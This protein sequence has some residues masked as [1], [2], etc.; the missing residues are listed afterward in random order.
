MV[1]PLSF[2][3]KKYLG[4]PQGGEYPDLFRVRE[5]AQDRQERLQRQRLYESPKRRQE[6]QVLVPPE[7]TTLVQ[8]KREGLLT[9]EDVK[10]FSE[11]G[12]FIP[13]PTGKDD[14]WYETAT[15]GLKR[16]RG[17]PKVPTQFPPQDIIREIPPEGKLIKTVVHNATGTEL[18]QLLVK[19]DGTV[20]SGGVYAGK[21]TSEMQMR[22]GQFPKRSHDIVHGID[23]DEGF[24]KMLNDDLETVLE[25]WHQK[26]DNLPEAIQ[27]TQKRDMPPYLRAY[28]DAKEAEE[29]ARQLPEIELSA[30]YSSEPNK[31]QE[32][33]RYKEGFTSPNQYIQGYL[34]LT[35][36]PA[37]W[38]DALKKLSAP[39]EE[40]AKIWAATT[41]APF[42]DTYF[43]RDDI[44]PPTDE[45]K[46]A[47]DFA[48]K[49]RDSYLDE[50]ME[51]SPGIWGVKGFL[52]LTF[53]PYWMPWGRLSMVLGG[54]T[55]AA[56]AVKK[57]WQ[58]VTKAEA[59]MALD[60]PVTAKEVTILKHADRLEALITKAL[61][62]GQ[63]VDKLLGTSTIKQ[64]LKL[65]KSG[66]I[67]GGVTTLSEL[68]RKGAA[69]KRITAVVKK[70]N[71]REKI[72]YDEWID[73]RRYYPK[74]FLELK[75]LVQKYQ[76]NISSGRIKPP[77][78]IKA[79]EKLY[80]VP[81]TK[82]FSV[83][84][85][86][87]GNL[88]LYPIAMTFG[89]RPIKS[90]LLPAYSFR[91]ASA[92]HLTSNLKLARTISKGETIYQIDP[93]VL[94]QKNLKFFY[95]RPSAGG[96]EI[97]LE[98]EAGIVIPKGQWTIVGGAKKGSVP[99][100]VT[101]GA[102]YK[103]LKELGN[104][105]IKNKKQADTDYRKLLKEYEEI[106][107]GKGVPKG[108]PKGVQS[109]ENSQI[110]ALAAKE[111][112]ES[113]PDIPGTRV[114]GMSE[115]NPSG[116]FKALSEGLP[117]RPSFWELPIVRNFV[118][119]INTIPIS[120]SPIGQISIIR[121]QMLDSMD[122]MVSHALAPM[123][124]LK[125]P[126]MSRKGGIVTDK[127]VVPTGASPKVGKASSMHVYDI[128]SYPDTYIIADDLKPWFDEMRSVT[129]E[130]AAYLEKELS[131]RGQKMPKIIGEDGWKYFHRVV[132]RIG[133]IK[134]DAYKSSPFKQRTIDI[135]GKGETLEPKI[136]YLDN[137]AEALEWYVKYAYRHIIDLYEKDLM[138]GLT[139][140]V[141]E[142]IPKTLTEQVL[143]KG[144]TLVAA[145]ELKALLKSASK[146]EE[147]PPSILGEAAIHFSGM[148][149]RIRAL[150]DQPL[151]WKAHAP[152]ELKLLKNDIDDIVRK[153]KK[154]NDAIGKT[155]NEA[156]ASVRKE[157]GSDT[158]VY[159]NGVERFF[160]PY[161][162][163][164]PYMGWTFKPRSFKFVYEDKGK[165]LSGKALAEEV[166]KQF[167]YHPPSLF[168]QLIEATGIGG[169][170]LRETKASLDLSFQF[171]QTLVGGLGLDAWNLMTLKP[172]ANWFKGAS[173]GV[174]MAFMPKS[175][176]KWASKPE[177]MAAQREMIL[178]R[179]LIQGSEY[180][181][182]ITH[183]A[184]LL[185]KTVV[186]KP[187]AVMYERAHDAF[188][189]GRVS[190]ATYMWMGQRP[191]ATKG[192]VAGAKLDR[193][194]DEMG[195]W[196]NKATG[197]LSTRGMG[198][199]PLQRALES[200]FFF[201]PRYNRAVLASIM[202]IAKGGYTGAQARESLLGLI[203]AGTSFFTFVPMAIGQTPRLNPM[204]TS[205]G[206][207]GAKFLT[208]KVGD[209][210]VG[211]GGTIYGLARL[212]ANNWSALTN[213]PE[214]LFKV[215]MDNPNIR[216]LRAKLGPPPSLAI[217]YV[218]GEGY[219]GN[220]TR[221]NLTQVLG[222][223]LNWLVP[224]WMSSVIGD[225]WYDMRG[226]EKQLDS[227]LEAAI[228]EFFGMRTI[229]DTVVDEFMELRDKYSRQ[230]F[231]VPYR[232]L[233]DQADKDS[234][235]E[236]HTDLTELEKD[237]S[238]YWQNKEPER[239]RALNE[240]VEKAKEEKNNNLETITITLLNDDEN[241]HGG[242]SAWSRQ[243]SLIKA[244]AS[245]RQEVLW[246]IKQNDTMK[247]FGGE[248][249][250][251]DWKN[252]QSPNDK[253]LDEYQNIRY[254]PSIL[255]TGLPDWEKRDSDL[256]T[257]LASQS[258]DVK[259]YIEENKNDYIKG[260]GPY[261]Q[262][263][264]RLLIFAQEGLEDYYD[265]IDDP[266]QKRKEYRE[267]NPNVDA[268][269]V[270]SRGLKAVSMEATSR[271]L[272]ILREYGVR[273]GILGEE[274]YGDWKP[275]WLLPEPEIPYHQPDKDKEMESGQSQ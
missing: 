22:I 190:T 95:E 201:A 13:F 82:D 244:Y 30:K 115:F 214:D 198:I 234:L 16:R 132:A 167:G 33:N 26:Y 8:P 152:G 49:V 138:I 116:R 206:G 136:V 196:I 66:E 65:F 150:V 109:A 159:F 68:N 37:S 120:R 228:P 200:V 100:I 42:R 41:T 36:Q 87:E 267:R 236:N 102:E 146:G 154:A 155:Y 259:E 233:E 23:W 168:G 251:E 130:I 45:E 250:V 215:S 226:D 89:M 221:D 175:Y 2:Y 199:P 209:S 122:G 62:K 239:N 240:I 188:T 245:G 97:V 157:L 193:R 93:K 273:R 63:S 229:P 272:D 263:V 121:N 125:A 207:D 268:K 40:T 44:R 110:E 72:N 18:Q 124:A 147:L 114:I 217:D 246:E 179:A 275:I 266:P 29:D 231:N 3:V 271:V 74:A 34:A 227:H 170:I 248:S 104:E 208:I 145:K 35:G 79:Q 70:I 189:A 269:L 261:T 164:K 58:A 265:I 247:F 71:S 202:D 126:K 232:D 123:K 144:K 262:K 86:P 254:N 47:G 241:E 133:E 205:R 76:L 19:P 56:A 270:I 94:S 131:K 192:M 178:H 113:Y 264:T 90:T 224:I 101:E 54:G 166:N 158:V 194:L 222:T 139:T 59:K 211:I 105:A 77:S 48:Y 52:E 119:L 163:I 191:F 274:W 57:F 180:T 238:A 21:L 10:E 237:F 1:R 96:K 28:E 255:A 12:E 203:A 6:M 210:Y 182:A 129:D 149:K 176:Y 24:S 98:A 69:L 195:M 204:P 50:Y 99:P 127:G 174:Q 235:Y 60:K 67:P 83:L 32:I 31:L 134:M 242:V 171:I 177:I 197:V 80:H 81:S 117:L 141:E 212:L 92:I 151:W 160:Q 184:P 137:P 148:V 230:D 161:E 111:I 128:L 260:L 107:S 213:N 39:L 173:R 218:T 84:V 181:E 64:T 38:D 225:E 253:A 53:P 88:L 165:V 143:Q 153:A 252:N 55:K 14:P 140:T 243:A 249:E 17:I 187:G 108:V 51:W 106:L 5:S 135:A 142:R 257:F 25:L 27:G 186:L 216:F 4:E 15:G 162:L 223:G 46:A 61:S 75:R 78:G 11:R 256:V 220:L 183:L 219:T 9:E 169:S 258:A 85:D 103:L 172:S 43:M 185:K 73:I 118:G 91:E 20:W 156:I 7:K 112:A